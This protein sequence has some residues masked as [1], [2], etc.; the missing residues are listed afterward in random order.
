MQISFIKLFGMQA[1]IM[2]VFMIN[3]ALIWKL[4]LSVGFSIKYTLT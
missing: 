3:A 2:R 1:R 4:K